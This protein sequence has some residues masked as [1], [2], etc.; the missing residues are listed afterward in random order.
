MLERVPEPATTRA[1]ARATVSPAAL[2]LGA[3]GAA[4]G[5]LASL[6]IAP[7]VILGVAGWA[8]GVA[9]SAARS[10]RRQRPRLE[11]VDPFAVPEPWRSYVQAA[12]VAQRKFE[13]AVAHTSP[14]PIR[15]RLRTISLRLAGSVQECWRIAH[16]GAAL[17]AALHSL[18]PEAVSHQLGQV[19]AERH[20][21]LAARQAEGPAG[22]QEGAGEAGSPAPQ[23]PPPLSLEALSRSEEAL[24]TQLQTA[25]RVEAVAGRASDQLRV[26]TAKLDGAVAGAVE[27]ALQAS[28]KAAAGELAGRLDAILAELES[29]RLALEET[30]AAQPPPSP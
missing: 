7:V 2:G 21:L 12:V 24:A 13:D 22:R 4:I 11:R 17:D 14:G 19:Q 30:D 29:L 9:L 20:R 15:D 27:V 3:G 26:L 10:R 6:P 25:R 1:V 23:H 5:L 8:G 28:G 16:H 18:D